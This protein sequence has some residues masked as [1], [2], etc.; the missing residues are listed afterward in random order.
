MRI[1]ELTVDEKLLLNYL[2]GMN[3]EDDEE[4]DLEPDY[5]FDDCR[6]SEFITPKKLV[7]IT[8]KLYAKGYLKDKNQSINHRFYKINTN[9]LLNLYENEV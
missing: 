7:M 2:I 5:F 6:W 4:Y 9:K 1:E 3:E 8:N